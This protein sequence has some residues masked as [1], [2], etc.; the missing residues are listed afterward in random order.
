MSSVEKG[1]SPWQAGGRSG[2]GEATVKEGKMRETERSE[3]GWGRGGWLMERHKRRGVIRE[4]VCSCPP[5]PARTLSDDPQNLFKK[6]REQELEERR[7]VY[8]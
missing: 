4:G 8:R 1:H 2:L 7:R 5:P 3:R 6:H